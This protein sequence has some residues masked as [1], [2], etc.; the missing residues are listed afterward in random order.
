MKIMAAVVILTDGNQSAVGRVFN[1][2]QST[3]NHAVQ[4]YGDEIRQ[5][6]RNVKPATISAGKTKADQTTKG[7]CNG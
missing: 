6:I 5:A 7:V 4:T 3:I 2:W 1:R